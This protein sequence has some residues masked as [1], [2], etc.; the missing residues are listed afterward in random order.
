ML[1]AKACLLIFL[2]V[3]LAH[4][5][6]SAMEFQ[7]GDRFEYQIKWSFLKV[8]NAE[9]S[10]DLAPLTPEG[11]EYLH[12]AFTAQT[13]GFADKI[14]KVRDRI[15]TWID[16]LTG[17]PI[18]YRKKQREGKTK[19]DIELHFDWD[20]MQARY[21]KNGEERTPVSLIEESYDPL[22]LLIAICNHEFTRDVPKLIATTDGKELVQIEVNRKKDRKLKTKSGRF[23]AQTL[24]V[25]TKELQ[26]VFEK[27]PDAR[28][29]I[30]LQ[31][32]SPR[33]PLRLES[34]VIVGSFFGEL[35]EMHLAPRPVQN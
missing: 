24:D 29:E 1:R 13:S 23:E 21:F 15:E 11:H 30:W 26:G 28:I 16:P 34:E 35:T 19:R 3:A 33:M 27:S 6:L 25:A 5:T 20:K 9:L 7:P 32:E 14:F 31:R 10:F 22:S 12:V 4:I 8:G 17:R 18:L 2:N